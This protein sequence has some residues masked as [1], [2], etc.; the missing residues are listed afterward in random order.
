[1]ARVEGRQV[2]RQAVEA[3]RGGAQVGEQRRLLAR[4]VVEL[5]ERRAQLGEE[6]VEDLEVAREVLAAREREIS[7]VSR[8]LLDEADDVLAAVGELGR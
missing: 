7:A 3:R 8:G 5:G 4:Q 2:D 1:M 6:V